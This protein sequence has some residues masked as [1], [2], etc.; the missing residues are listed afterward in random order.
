LDM[1]TVLVTLNEISKI[2][3]LVVKQS[4]KHKNLKHTG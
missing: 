2:C 3:E 1:T 4:N